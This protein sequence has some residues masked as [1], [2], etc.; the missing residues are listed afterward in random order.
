MLY[1]TMLPVTEVTAGS[2]AR[3]LGRLV[4]IA[5]ENIGKEAAVALFEVLSRHLAT[6]TC[7]RLEPETSQIRIRCIIQSL[8]TYCSE[9]ESQASVY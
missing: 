1:L 6:R 5:L 4:N 8:A 3:R 2:I 9:F 7:P